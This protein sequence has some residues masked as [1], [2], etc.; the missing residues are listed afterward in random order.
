[1]LFHRERYAGGGGM[2]K[3][4]I[5][6]NRAVVINGQGGNFGANL[7]VNARNGLNGADITMLRWVGKTV[8][9][10]EKWAA[11]VLAA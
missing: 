10:A 8:K 5:E 4:I 7:Y 11:K 6:G 2:K 9:G 3:I 1:M